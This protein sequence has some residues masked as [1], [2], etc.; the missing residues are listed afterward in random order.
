MM[1]LRK[2]ERAKKYLAPQIK[3]IT[4]E[5]LKIIRETESDDLTRVMQMIVCTYME[6]LVPVAVIICQHLVGT[7][8]QV[9]IF[10]YLHSDF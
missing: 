4:P 7:F 1:L 10:N 8:A 3:E 6:Q 9:C 5:V 2:S